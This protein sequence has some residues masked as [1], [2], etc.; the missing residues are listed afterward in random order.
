MAAFTTE[1][2]VR[3]TMQV[4]DTTVATSAL[5]TQSIDDAHTLV[6]ARLDDG[7]DLE[8]PVEALV[9][10]ETLLAGAQL[11]RSLAGRAA[12]QGRTVRVGGQ[13]LETGRQFAALRQLAVETEA[14]AWETLAPFLAANG[15][16]ENAT[17]TDTQ[18]VWEHGAS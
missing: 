3:L 12:S 17:A 10:G 13:Q 15:S 18:G 14:A 7:V 4:E 1:A 9:L 8:T 2:R 5:V 6:L 16:R 11:L